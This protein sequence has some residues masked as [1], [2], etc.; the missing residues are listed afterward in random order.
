LANFI[1]NC[2]AAFGALVI[3]RALFDHGGIYETIKFYSI[4]FIYELVLTIVTGS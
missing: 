4:D 1:C 2:L 3:A